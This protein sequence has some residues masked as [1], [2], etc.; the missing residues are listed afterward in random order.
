MALILSAGK[1][2]TVVSSVGVGV[3]PL[4]DQRMRPRGVPT[5]TSPEEAATHFTGRE[6]E[7]ER[8]RTGAPSPAAAELAF[9]VVA[10]AGPQPPP[11]TASDK[12]AETRPS[13]KN[14]SDAS[15]LKALKGDRRNR[16]TPP[17][18]RDGS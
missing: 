11:G 16:R 3:S 7:K 2:S 12:E 15:L 9:V 10:G 1:P 14:L 13:V 6:S 18:F 8:T 4:I 17:N 5:Q